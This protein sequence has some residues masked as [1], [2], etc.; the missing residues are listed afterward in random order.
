M[1]HNKIVKISILLLGVF[2][3]I[4]GSIRSCRNEVRSF[5]ILQSL[6]Q[7]RVIIKED[8]PSRVTTLYIGDSFIADWAACKSDTTTLF[9]GKRGEVTDWLIAWLDEQTLPSTI[10]TVV[11]AIGLNDV[12]LNRSVEKVIA[13]LHHIVMHHQLS[14]RKIV[15]LEIPILLEQPNTF[16]IDFEHVN[17]QILEINKVAKKKYTNAVCKT[18]TLSDTMHRN[19]EIRHPDGIHFNCSGYSILSEQLGLLND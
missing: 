10:Q 18:L 12:L 5:F 9:I 16:F 4:I 14:G 8:I 13:Q 1:F 17:N 15:L 2:F 7:N 11:V 19:P 6:E 3:L